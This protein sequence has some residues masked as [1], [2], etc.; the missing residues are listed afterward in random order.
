MVVI[1]RFFCSY[2]RPR[3]MANRCSRR[4]WSRQ[5]DCQ[6]QDFRSPS[7]QMVGWRERHRPH[8][9]RQTKKA[10]ASGRAILLTSKSGREDSNLRPL[11]PNQISRLVAV[12]R[13]RV[14]FWWFE[15]NPLRHSSPC[16]TLLKSEAFIATKSTFSLGQR[17]EPFLSASGRYQRWALPTASHAEMQC[18]SRLVPL[19]VMP[20]PSLPEWH[21]EFS[22]CAPHEAL[23][24]DRR[25]QAMLLPNWDWDRSIINRK[26]HRLYPDPFRGKAEPGVQ[27]WSRSTSRHSISWKRATET[28]DSLAEHTSCCLQAGRW[29]SMCRPQSDCDGKEIWR[30]ACFLLPGSALLIQISTRIGFR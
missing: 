6:P 15:L 21:R 30:G 27:A 12:C 2:H 23:L 28:P 11:G 1:R 10:R 14:E 29:R 20:T 9:R 13:K 16:W 22:D 5:C 17:R 26:I 19:L 25:Y 8:N 24:R 18:R 4:C 3:C 7:S